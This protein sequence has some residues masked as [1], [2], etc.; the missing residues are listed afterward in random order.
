MLRSQVNLSKHNSYASFG[1]LKP[2]SVICIAPYWMQ[3]SVIVWNSPS[4]YC[5]QVK[6]CIFQSFIQFWSFGEEDFLKVCIK[7]AMLKLALWLLFCRYCR[8]LHHLNRFNYTSPR[9]ICVQY[10]RILMSSFTEEDFSIFKVLP[11]CV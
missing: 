11:K 4:M 10:L 1:K 2:F 9:T 7:F 5:E 8:W 6:Y 3:H